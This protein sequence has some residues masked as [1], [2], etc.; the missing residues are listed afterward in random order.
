MAS[1]L[2]SEDHKFFFKDT[3]FPITD[4]VGSA[5][6]TS[7][8]GDSSYEGP[9]EG[10]GVVEDGVDDADIW[11]AANKP[12][13]FDGDWTMY[14]KMN[15]LDS[16]D[17]LTQAFVGRPSGTGL[18]ILWDDLGS[19][20]SRINAFA[21]SAGGSLARL[22]LGEEPSATDIIGIAVS[23]AHTGNLLNIAI[24]SS[25]GTNVSLEAGTVSGTS[26]GAF[27]IGDDGLQ[28]SFFNARFLRM[29]SINGTAH[30]VTDLEDTVLDLMTS[31]E[32]VVTVSGYTDQSLLL[33]L[34]S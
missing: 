16:L 32:S 18:S 1:V 33:T 6:S 20:A 14:F 17:G 24:R 27:S 12:V 5:D 21:F 11:S 19:P 4:L 10:N 3:S 8:N 22:P 7:Q 13:D 34:F 2:G 30:S 26:G 31:D 23:F 9:G 29:G 28:S 25:T 15:L